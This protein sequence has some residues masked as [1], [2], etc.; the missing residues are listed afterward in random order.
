MNFD[1]QSL[2]EWLKA[3]RLSLNVNK[4]KLLIFRSKYKKEVFSNIFIKLDGT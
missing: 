1:L 4:S 3:N 2:V